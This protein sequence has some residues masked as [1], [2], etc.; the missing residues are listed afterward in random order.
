MALSLAVLLVMIPAA[1]GAF[2]SQLVLGS[3]GATALAPK[4]SCTIAVTFKPTVTGTQTGSLT[5]TGNITPLSVSLTGTG[6]SAPPKV[7]TTPES[8]I[9]PTVLIGVKSAAQT[10]TL[11][12]SGTTSVSISTIGISGD[13]SKTGTCAT[14]LG[15]GQSCIEN[16]YFT[17]TA[18]GT[19]T[20]AL[21]FTLSSGVITA[22]LTGTATA[23]AT[24]LLTVS[25]TSLAFNGYVVGDNPDQIV[26]IKNSN[27]VAAGIASISMSGSAAFTFT[28]TCATTLAAGASCT[29]DVTFTPAAVGSYAGTLYVNESAGAIHKVPLS[30]TAVTGD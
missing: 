16:V 5:V 26:T 9:F 2:A 12:N 10:V 17:P 19:R 13:F 14:S 30:G 4:A 22:G 29:V 6:A 21:T 11:K 7:A 25:P 28:K 23:A 3:T 20:G 1:S 24:A 8:L 15:A 27:G 18:A